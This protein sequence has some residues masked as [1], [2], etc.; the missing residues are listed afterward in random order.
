M[1]LPVGDLYTTEHDRLVRALVRWGCPAQDAD[2]IVQETFLKLL[3]RHEVITS[4]GWLFV[5]AHHLLLDRVDRRK[6]IAFE[7]FD[8]AR[9]DAAYHE[10]GFD[11]IDFGQRLECAIQ[12]LTKRQQHAIYL[13]ISGVYHEN[14]KTPQSKMMKMRAK[15]NLLTALEVHS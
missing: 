8:P 1:S 13:L 14:V 6:C 11:L 9:H 5:V 10:E 12:G 4:R 2:D 3:S 15:R 7:S